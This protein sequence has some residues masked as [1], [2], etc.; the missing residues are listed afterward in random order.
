MVSRL[1]YKCR[2]T[3]IPFAIV[4]ER[5]TSSTCSMCGKEED[6]RIKRGLYRCKRYEKI[7]NADCNGAVNHE[8]RYLQIPLS[9]GSG[10]GVVG[11]LASPVVV[12]WDG[13]IWRP[14]G[15]A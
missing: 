4:D 14:M 12:H 5:D 8:K 13:H 2:E 10:I 7:F 3:G 6:G 9:K 11:S 1:E 15:E